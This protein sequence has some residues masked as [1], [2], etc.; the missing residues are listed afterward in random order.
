M[1]IVELM[2]ELSVLKKKLLDL[3]M[4]KE[5]VQAK[6]LHEFQHGRYSN[7][8]LTSNAPVKMLNWSRFYKS[9]AIEVE[10]LLDVD[11]NQH[12]LFRMIGQLDPQILV[13][14]IK[15]LDDQDEADRVIECDNAIQRIRSLCSSLPKLMIH[16]LAS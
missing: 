15:R 9:L 12:S 11:N 8:D 2:S 13:N 1:T 14:T 6:I 4:S 16:K 7:I 5:S 10:H 3:G